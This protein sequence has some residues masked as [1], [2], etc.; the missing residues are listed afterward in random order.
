MLALHP[1][2]Q[3]GD[4]GIMSGTVA[5]GPQE[6]EG[7]MPLAAT[8]EVSCLDGE[9]EGLVEGRVEA[10]GLDGRRELLGV[11]TE[12]HLKRIRTQIRGC[13]DPI[14][15][16]QWPYLKHC[17]CSNAL[18]IGLPVITKRALLNLIPALLKENYIYF[19][20]ELPL[21]HILFQK[22]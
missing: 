19:I 20:R 13:P 10:V 3:D 21:L 7:S 18:E 17:T 15:W 6:V 12:A 1:S 4:V 5:S 14:A 11:G 9:L 8:F 22:H 2:I 16:A